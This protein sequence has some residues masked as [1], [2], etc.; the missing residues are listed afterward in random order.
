MAKALS[1]S[2][3]QLGPHWNQL[4]SD[5]GECLG[6]GKRQATLAASPVGEELVASFIGD[7]VRRAN[8]LR[9]NPMPVVPFRKF[10]DNWEAWIGY[11][12]VWVASPRP[13]FCSSDITVFFTVSETE[14]F[15]QIIRAEWVGLAK[16][17]SEW[18]FNPRDAGHPHWQID[19]VETIKLD[20]DLAA[21]RALLTEAE[22]REFGATETKE[23]RD[24]PWY[25]LD[26]IHFASAMRPWT[27]KKIAHGPTELA[28]I[29]SWV[30]ET[31]TLLDIEF[32]RL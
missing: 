4:T 29:R 11:R 24:P 19:A 8:R 16:L 5:F 1:V 31:C 15:Q 14:V 17:G 28:G 13:V 26:R 12:E 10:Q 18:L 20:A 9:G 6:I 2:Q 7:A 32:G 27:D 23:L 21:A 30:K 3:G 22:P 25:G